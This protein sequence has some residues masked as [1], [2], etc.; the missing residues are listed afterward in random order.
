MSLEELTNNDFKVSDVW[1]AAFLEQSEEHAIG[2]VLVVN[3]D[4]VVLAD[5][6]F[7]DL[8]NRII[9]SVAAKDTRH[10]VAVGS[11]FGDR[12]WIVALRLADKLVPR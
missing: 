6:I 1:G 11:A 3:V 9:S 4:G 10:F 8:R 2:L 7:P 12:G 5:R